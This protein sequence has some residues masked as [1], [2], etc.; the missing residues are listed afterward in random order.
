M[1]GIQSMNLIGDKITRKTILEYE[2]LVRKDPMLLLWQKNKLQ[3]F[4]EFL[5]CVFFKCHKPLE[6][7][8]HSLWLVG[9][10]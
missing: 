7:Q 4:Y 3:P 1:D 9:S 10:F 8:I 5:E 6:L 2:L